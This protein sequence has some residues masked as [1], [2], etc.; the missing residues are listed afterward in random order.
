MKRGVGRK[1]IAALLGH[2]TT[3]QLSRWETGTIPSLPNALL[4]GHVL[5]L[6]V[7][8]L[9]KGLRE[10]LAR[11]VD[12]RRPHAADRIDNTSESTALREAMR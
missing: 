3:S 1:K 11:T 9:F 8:I 7:E 5:Q 12:A 6:P 4:L 2:R 10:E